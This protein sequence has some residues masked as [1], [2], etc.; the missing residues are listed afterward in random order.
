MSKRKCL[1][2]HEYF[3]EDGMFSLSIGNIED[4]AGFSCENCL[5]PYEQD[6]FF[7]QYFPILSEC[8]VMA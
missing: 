1:R 5:L 4:D 3:S 8:A 6:Y 7:E 2:C